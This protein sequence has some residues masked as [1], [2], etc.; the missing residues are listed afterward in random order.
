MGLF[1]KK[2]TKSAKSVELG[3][4]LFK[5]INRRFFLQVIPKNND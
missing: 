3:P 4:D 2:P 5:R 1:G